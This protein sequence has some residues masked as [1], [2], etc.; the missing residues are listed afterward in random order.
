[1]ASVLQDF[2]DALALTVERTG[3]AVV[4]VEAR[5]RL[6]ATGIVWSAAGVI[7]TAH[8]VVEQDDHVGIGLHDGRTLSA[9]LLGRDP[10]TDVAVLQAQIGQGQLPLTV[11]TWADPADLRVGHL[12]LALGRPGQ[13]VLATFGIISA[14]GEGWRTPAGG[15]VDHY[16]QSDVVMLPGFS[17]GPLVDAAGHIIGMNTSAMLRGVSLTIPAPTL[18]RVVETILSHGHV[19]RGYLGVSAQAARLPAL[20][21]QQLQQESGLLLGSVEADGPADKAGLFMGDTLISLDNQPVRHLDDLMALLTG[22]R[23]GRPLSARI[24][25]GGQVQTLDV[26]IGERSA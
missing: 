17:G 21:A 10:T 20:L 6:P 9:R 7:V 2:S 23:V 3:P 5:R 14:L 16:L 8:H 22:E 25:R 4:R 15:E 1:M 12:A 26:V 13:R 18:R 24:V 11:P 19:R